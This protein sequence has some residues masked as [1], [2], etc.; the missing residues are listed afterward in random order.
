[1]PRIK[2]VGSEDNLHNFLHQKK[3]CE[4]GWLWM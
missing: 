1:M 3:F 2:I 4:T